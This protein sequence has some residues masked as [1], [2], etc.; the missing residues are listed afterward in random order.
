M[1]TAQVRKH[2]RLLMSAEA[3]S[4][5]IVMWPGELS[6][7]PS[8]WALC[9][10]NNS[11]PDLRDVFLYGWGTEAVGVTGGSDSS[12]H[13]HLNGSGANVTDSNNLHTHTI[14]TGSPMHVADWRRRAVSA[15]SGETPIYND[16]NSGVGSASV[17]YEDAGP[18]SHAHT[19][20]S[21]SHNHTVSSAEAGDPAYTRLFFI[22]KL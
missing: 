18:F 9:D 12:E 7:I 5:T 8:G 15:G 14:N 4:G 1:N 6:T 16:A 20:T 13:S 17:A 19:L 21:A 2:T 10:G 11:T 3:P 22:M